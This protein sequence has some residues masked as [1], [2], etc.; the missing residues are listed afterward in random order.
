MWIFIVL[1]VVLGFALA[2]RSMNW[3]KQASAGDLESYS[4]AIRDRHV[5]SAAFVSKLDKGFIGIGLDGGSVVLGDAQGE[6]I[7]PMGAVR[8]V[9]L[10]V[11]GT[12]MAPADLVRQKINNLKVRVTVDDPER[13]T[14]DFL[15]FDWPN[16]RAVSANTPYIGQVLMQ[17]RRILERFPNSS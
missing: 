11:D 10:L 12:P 5:L 16:K 17:A 8:G 4:Q 6:R 13:P 3:R 7:Y 15:L 14:H 2:W 9:A 1:A